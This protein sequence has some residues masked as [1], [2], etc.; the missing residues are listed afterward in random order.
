MSRSLHLAFG[1]FL[2]IFIIGAPVCYAYVRQNQLR[3]LKVV[4]DNVLYRSGQLSL[5]GLQQTVHDLGIKTV[6]SLRPNDS[7]LELEPEEAFC[8]LQEIN[9]V[10]ISPQRWWSAGGA[11]PAEQ[12]VKSFIKIM[13]NPANHPVLIHCMRGVHRTGAFCA[14]YR[15]EF[16]GWSNADAIEELR[17]CG[18]KELEDEF[19]ILGF[20]EAFKPSDRAR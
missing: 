14:V 6:I 13:E 2:T 9:F 16:Q 19:D 12:G 5:K 1:L 10:R 17:S 3:N 7:G 8:N 15:M 4:E 20:L 18:Y 11:I